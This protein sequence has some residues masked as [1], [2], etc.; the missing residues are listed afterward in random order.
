MPNLFDMHLFGVSDSKTFANTIA[1]WSNVYGFNMETMKNTV[2]RDAQVL[3]LDASCVVTDMVKFKE[4]D[5]MKVKVDD[6]FK[7][8]SDFELAVNC[9]CEL[10]GIGSSFDAHFN[11]DSLENKVF[12]K[13]KE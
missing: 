2:C 6:V 4:I 1:F 3:S 7:F 10:T 12:I 5:C 9:D 13:L 8:E 11:H